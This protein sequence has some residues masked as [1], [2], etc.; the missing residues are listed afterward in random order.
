MGTSSLIGIQREDKVEYIYCHWDGY[1][2][3]VGATLNRYYSNEETVN[4]LMKLGD[5]SCLGNKPIS[6]PEYWEEK[7]YKLNPDY[8]LAYR[9]RGES[10]VNSK[11]IPLSKYNF[12][13]DSMFINYMYL[14]RN[15]KWY[16]LRYNYDDWMELNSQLHME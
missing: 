10:N 8:T 2:D 5:I 16:Y 13:D 15:G 4:Q 12:N 9:D 11:I 1:L 7:G 3:G 14:F 6:K